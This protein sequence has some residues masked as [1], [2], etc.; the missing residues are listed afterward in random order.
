[1]RPSPHPIMSQGAN[2]DHKLALLGWDDPLDSELTVY[3]QA[4]NT[5]P[6]DY[7]VSLI[8]EDAA[9]NPIGR[10][11]G[12]PAGYDYPATRWPVGRPLFGRYPLPLPAGAQ[13][14]YYVSLGV[15]APTRPKDWTSAMWPTTPRASGSGWGQSR[16]RAR[17]EYPGEACVASTGEL[18]RRRRWTKGVKREAL[19]ARK[20]EGEG[21]K[22]AAIAFVAS[23]SSPPGY[24]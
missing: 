7:Q 1:M 24:T 2:F 20:A 13:G 9:G 12:R 18:E 22:G 4:L 17:P 14:D 10:W 6:E 19:R 5:L 21:T 3:W 16:F 15:Y 23:C 11:D 8:L